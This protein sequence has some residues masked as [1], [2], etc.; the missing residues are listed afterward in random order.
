[1]NYLNLHAVVVV[2]TNVNRPERIVVSGWVT[3]EDGSEDWT[4]LRCHQG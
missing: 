1:M 4:R 3:V 2:Q